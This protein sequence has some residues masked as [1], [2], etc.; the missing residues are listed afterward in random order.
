MRDLFEFHENQ[1]QEIIDILSGYDLDNLSYDDCSELHYKVLNIGFTFEFGL[2]AVPSNL[3]RVESND[4]IIE[5]RVEHSKIEILA[6]MK[7]GLV[8][9]SV[10]NF[11]DLHNYVDANCY[12]GFCEEGYNPSENWVDENAIQ[13]AVG[14]WLK[15]RGQFPFN[16]GDDY[17]TI[18]DGKTVL[19]CWDEESEKMHS[20][21]KEYYST[22]EEANLALSE[23]MKY[24]FRINTPSFLKETI[25]AG[26]KP[27]QL[28][29]KRG[30]K[31]LVSFL[32]QLGKRC[33]EIDDPVLNRIM[34]DMALYDLPEPTTKEFEIMM[35]SIYKKEKEFLK[36]K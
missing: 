28:E 2:D 18:E 32:G 1:P 21:E 20:P 12:G 35:D 36:N 15:N 6:D 34:F 30:F 4:E 13:D 16:E 17:W 19:S 22:E 10:K 29:L 33:A 11:G 24:H 8:P 9:D 5:K 3:R 14:D 26:L 23:N 27:N 31:V 25:S 7:S